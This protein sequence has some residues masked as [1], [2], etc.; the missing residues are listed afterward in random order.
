MNE[1]FLQLFVPSVLK[2]FDIKVSKTLRL[3][4]IRDMLYDLLSQDIDVDVLK[5]SNPILCDRESGVIF[6]INLSVAEL[7]LRNG[8]QLM[9]I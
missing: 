3:Y 8:S 6:N 4:E 9:L 1:I 7:A 5:K 2:T